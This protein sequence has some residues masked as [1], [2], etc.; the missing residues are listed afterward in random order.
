MKIFRVLVR[1]PKR[2]CRSVINEWA[3]IGGGQLDLLDQMSPLQSWG[4]ALGI[5]PDPRV[6]P[7]YGSGRG[8]G[9]SHFGFL[10]KSYFDALVL[11]LRTRRIFNDLFLQVTEVSIIFLFFLLL[12]SHLRLSQQNNDTVEGRLNH[13]IAISLYQQQPSS[14]LYR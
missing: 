6:R 13:V 10:L 3:K 7:D 8:S 11:A 5:T 2:K 12:V 4:T 9:R 1:A 14:Y